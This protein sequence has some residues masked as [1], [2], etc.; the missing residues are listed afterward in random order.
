MTFQLAT[1][2]TETHV[3]LYPGPSASAPQDVVHVEPVVLLQVWGQPALLVTFGRVPEQVRAHV[4][5]PEAAPHEPAVHVTLILPNAVRPAAH[6]P[7]QLPPL[8]TEVA[9]VLQFQVALVGRLAGKE[10]LVQ[11]AAT[12][13]LT[14]CTLKYSSCFIMS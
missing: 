10:A 11:A 13:K 9:V 14:G 12:V 6:T 2:P 4:M 8:G 5:E 7:E 1:A 3:A